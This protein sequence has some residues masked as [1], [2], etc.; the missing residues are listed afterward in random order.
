MTFA[1]LYDQKVIEKEFA[2]MEITTK[3]RK[4]ANEWVKKIK[5]KELEKEVENYDTFRETILIELL[6]YP[7][8]EIKFE[9]KNVEFSIKDIK[10]RTHVVFEAKGTKTKDLFG[11]QHYGK[12]EQWHPVIQT[13]SN[14]QR[15][16]PPAAYGVCTN[17]NDFVLLDKELGI[18]KC[19]RF[20]FTDIEKNSEKL[21]EFM[22][23]F[24]Y[25]KL[26]K[27]D[28]LKILYDKSVTA[29]K[30][31]TNE[32]YK[33]FH[34][35]R[36]MLIREFQ[37][38]SE[39]KI[40]KNEAVHYTQIFLNRLIF[41][42][43]VEDREYVSDKQLFSKRIFKIL[44]ND[45]IIDISNQVYQSITELFRA[46][47]IGS[48]SLGV[49]GFNGQLFSG[50]IPQQIN[51]LDLKDSTF[52]DEDRQN[53]KLLKSTKLN[54]E[55]QKIINSHP[56]LNPIISNL[57]IM[58]SFDFTT[59]VDV[60]ILGHIFEQSISDLETI[61]K[62]GT[63]TRKK[64]G[65]YYTPEGITDYLCRNAIIQNLSESNVSTIQEL[66]DEYEDNLD[67]LEA[68]FKAIKILDP[69]CGSGAFLNKSIDILLEIH[70]EQFFYH[71]AHSHNFLQYL[72]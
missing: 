71:L 14:M 56:K 34:E 1:P 8:E 20:T 28:S 44:K 38:N 6:E 60:N 42:F 29:E 41:I 52:F 31:F 50:T 45:Q 24:S 61:K 57:L 13:N 63:F 15:F 64:E 25:E 62:E 32:F 4:L 26:V 2:K 3:Q 55:A 46:F 40:T 37:E 33:L 72:N 10:G 67:K 54:D 53:S 43:F 70:K 9:E 11:R 5:N 69:A 16:A 27:K 51:F 59:E 35:T 68:R 30:E 49:A 23:I 36:L 48:S 17:Y 65:V 39:K 18:T 21:K 12:E 19:H 58:E 66:I 22:G 47:D 7:K